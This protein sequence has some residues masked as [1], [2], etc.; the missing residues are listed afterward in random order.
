MRSLQHAIHHTRECYQKEERAEI[1]IWH[2][3]G[4]LG[5]MEVESE[6]KMKGRNR[7]WK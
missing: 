2:S 6:G 7:D 3:I 4:G 5:Q 1:I